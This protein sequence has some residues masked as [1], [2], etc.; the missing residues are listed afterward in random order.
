[1]TYLPWCLL[2]STM[3]L[4]ALLMPR[5]ATLYLAGAWG[6]L[7]ILAAVWDVAT[8]PPATVELPTP[9]L[10]DLRWAR[11]SSRTLPT[12]DDVRDARRP[13]RAA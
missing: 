11:P 1:M 4:A 3:M 2:V 8:R 13:P 6:T 9:T 5:E 10:T 12:P 7:G